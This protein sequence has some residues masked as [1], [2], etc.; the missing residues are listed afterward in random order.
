MDEINNYKLIEFAHEL[1]CKSDHIKDNASK[2]TIV[3]GKAQFTATFLLELP[4]TVTTGVTDLGVKKEEP[5]TFVF[6][7]YFPAKA[8]E[9]YLR[10][11]F[12]KVFPHINPTEKK[13][14]PCIYYGSN[15]ELLQQPNFFCEILDQVQS[16][17]DKAT[18]NSLTDYDQGWEPMRTDISHGSISMPITLM[19]SV[20]KQMDIEKAGIFYVRD[21]NIIISEYLIYEEEKLD[22]SRNSLCLPFE[23][24]DNSTEYMPNNIHT[25]ADL[26]KLAIDLNIEDFTKTINDCAKNFQQLQLIFLAFYIKRPVE[27]IGNTSDIEIIHFALESRYQ[28]KINS[29]PKDVKVF[30]L[31]TLESPST[32]LLQKFSGLNK[33]DTNKEMKIVQIG[34][35][36]LG[37]KIITHLARTGISNN[38]T[39]IDNGV[40]SSHNHARHA[41]TNTKHCPTQYKSELV[42]LALK[43]IGINAAR[44]SK[45]SVLDEKQHILE[46]KIL[47]DSTADISIR[48]FLIDNEIKSEVIYTVLHDMSNLGLLFIESKNRNVRLDDLVAVFYL[49]CYRNPYLSKILCTNKANYETVGQG[50]GSFTTVVTDA[51]I[52]LVS[53]SMSTIIQQ[54]LEKG[55]TDEGQLYF[56]EVTDDIN[57]KWNQIPILPP[58]VLHDKTFDMEVR[59][60]PDVE[61]RI[62]EQTQEH[63]SNE[64]GGVLVGHI[65]LINKTFNIVDLIDAPIDSK[66]SPGYFELGT[67]GLNSKIADYETKS[68][69]LLTYIGTWHSHPI[70]GSASP[71]DL[72]TKLEILRDRENYPM[73]NLIN[74]KGT[75]ICT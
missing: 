4:S 16:W 54:N 63:S 29:I 62:H 41:L 73:V 22:N 75:I 15:D 11:N 9:I 49:L 10:D 21:E 61:K 58:R 56:G 14:N 50:C 19:E 72:K 1:T 18:T 12:P 43:E 40:F 51:K 44:V 74:S 23:S 48:N 30:T 33:R 26:E 7:K 42:F 32:S 36:S 2:I 46:D 68:N 38:I 53:S 39:L 34:C 17:L 67:K 60:H 20:V 55:I 37:S 70:G 13:V 57:I 6:S 45:N 71:I 5:V 35:G 65:S 64:T 3:E 31:S 69:G 27:L 8:P 25:L 52:S 66:R 59:I 28:K 24:L 47:I